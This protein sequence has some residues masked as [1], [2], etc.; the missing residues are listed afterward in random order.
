M[1]ILNN[2]FGQMDVHTNGGLA[3]H[4]HLD[5][6]QI[7]AGVRALWSYASIWTGIADHLRIPLTDNCRLEF[8][9]PLPQQGNLSAS[10]R[11]WADSYVV[12][13]IAH[14]L[15]LT[16]LQEYNATELAH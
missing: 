4:T 12:A 16:T 13:E 9:A 7:G 15:I 8:V 5:D 14:R 10:A 11:S 3:S 2:V 1:T 6:F